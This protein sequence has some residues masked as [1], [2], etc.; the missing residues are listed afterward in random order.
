MKIFLFNLGTIE[1]R[2]HGW[3]IEGFNTLFSQEVI[4]WGPIP[5]R[6]FIFKEREIPIISLFEPTTI[7][8]LYARLPEGWI[9][10]IVVCET[11]VLNYVPD[12]HLCPSKTLLF[13]RDAWSDTIFNRRLVESFDFLN[14]AS[15]DRTLYKDLQVNLLPLSNCAVSVI[16]EDSVNTE[17]TERDIDVIAIATYNSS[18][19]HDRYRTYYSLSESNKGN[20]NIKYIGGI[21]YSEIFTYYN[22]SKIVIDWAHTLSN[23][24]Y[25]AAMS[26]CLLFSHKD[27]PLI[28]EFWIPW[29]EYIPYDDNNALELAKYYVENPDEARRVIGNAREKISKA[30]PGWGQLVWDNVFLACETN[31][32]VEARIKRNA[33]LPQ[34]TLQSRSATPLLFNYEYNTNYPADWKNLY[35]KRI[36][37][38]LSCPGEPAER[39]APLIEAARVAF[40]L[41]HDDL[42]LKYLDELSEAV[43]DY[44]WTY[45]LYGRIYFSGGEYQNALASLKR[46]IECAIMSPGLIKQNVLP[47]IEKG[48][49]C[50]YRRVLNYMWEPVYNHGNE[51]QAKALLHLSHELSGDVYQSTGESSRAIDS[52]S[53]AIKSLPVPDCIYKLSPLLIQA[54]EFDKLFQYANLGIN[55]SPYDSIII[56][57][58]AYAL[59]QLRQYRNADKILREHRRILKDFVGVRKTLFIRYSINLYLLLMLVGK[60]PVSGL[61]L[62]LIDQ[63]KKRV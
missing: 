61:I 15:I 41:K 14:H 37:K 9:P 12:M 33:N 34:I 32:S 16:S 8:D 54:S 39:I 35:F 56:L 31:V 25:E 40:L 10:D 24:S 63:L 5:D 19:Y 45:Y 7:N 52:Y 60:Q 48:N 2:I 22:R 42:S 21:K 23:R 58:K 51:Y 53:D 38:A 46:A 3:G 50:D 62:V 59:I 43:P 17:F 18:F 57:Y 36:E 4:L 26:G 20:L 11:S 49:T 28:K 29:E 47:V 27:N 55:D 13:T 6:N 1:F 44:A 30:Q